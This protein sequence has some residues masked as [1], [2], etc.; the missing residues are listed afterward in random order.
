MGSALGLGAFLKPSG[1]RENV[2]SAS[3]DESEKQ[4]PVESRLRI[5][6]ALDNVAEGPFRE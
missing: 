2:A 3:A 5:P 6:A 4:G 1:F